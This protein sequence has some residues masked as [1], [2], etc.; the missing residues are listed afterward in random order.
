MSTTDW[1][2][3]EH[4]Y[5]PASN[6]PELLANAEKASPPKNY[7]EEPWFTLWSSLYHQGDVYTASYAAVPILV[8]IA[9]R[10]G[11]KVARECIHLAAS[12]EMERHSKEAPRIPAALVPAYEAALRN[13][14][15][16]STDLLAPTEDELDQRIFRGS[17]EIFRGNIESGREILDPKDD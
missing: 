14:E 7:E 13:G 10:R 17:I 2:A 8:G 16:L 1:K 6:M 5:G 12:I 11:G 4:A 3:L 15:K 9:G